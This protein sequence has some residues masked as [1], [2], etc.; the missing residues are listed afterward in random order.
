[1]NEGLRQLYQ[2]IIVEHGRSPRNAGPLPGATHEATADNPLCGDMVTMRLVVEADRVSRVAFEGHGCTLSQAAASLLSIR[3]IDA[4]VSDARA[5]ADR[6]TAFV[7]EA[8]ESPIPSD[9]GDLAA[10]AG[11]REFKSRQA[12][13]SLAASALLRALPPRGPAAG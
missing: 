8:P 3:L 5:L 2:S 1:M 10:F 7:R 4:G 6:F 11:V 12:C 13:A 9:L